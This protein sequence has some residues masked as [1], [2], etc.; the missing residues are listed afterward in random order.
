[1]VLK[2]PSTWGMINKILYFGHIGPS[3]VPGQ[4]IQGS[5]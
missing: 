3:D 5:G 4:T 2:I 1:M